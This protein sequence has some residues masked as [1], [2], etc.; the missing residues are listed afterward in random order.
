MVAVRLERVHRLGNGVDV[1]QGDILQPVRLD[2]PDPVV[3]QEHKL[4]YDTPSEYPLGD[5]VGI[6]LVLRR[7]PVLEHQDVQ[8]GIDIRREQRNGQYDQHDL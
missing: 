2:G 3:P 8:T 7:R 1:D 4:E 6:G 5:T